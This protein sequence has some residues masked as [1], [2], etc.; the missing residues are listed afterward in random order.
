[1]LIE[2]HCPNGHVLHVKEKHAGRMGAC[3]YSAA[4]VR[5]PFP[6][7]IEATA[8]AAMEGL[9]AS[10]SVSQSSAPPVSP[11]PRRPADESRDVLYADRAEPS[12]ET[13]SSSLSTSSLSSWGGKTKLCL[14]CGK[15][16]SQSFTI[17][18][19]CGTPLAAYRH[20]EIGKDGDVVVVHLLLRQI[21]DEATVKGLVDELLS[22]VSRIQNHDFV[23]SLAKVT[24]VSS[25]M[26]GKLV[27]LQK[28]MQQKGK[29][30]RLINVRPEVREV[31]TVTKLD[32][33]LRV[34]QQ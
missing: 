15:A 33:I 1:M 27:M 4:P 29:Q 20:L 17:C 30:L 34:Q 24:S 23:L 10:P 12:S 25:L 31:L 8:A 28:K 9:V 19:R 32:Q 21:V 6:S 3:P 13:S 5:V 7:Q 22:V 11:T 2:V 16:V 18:P 26:L 14:E